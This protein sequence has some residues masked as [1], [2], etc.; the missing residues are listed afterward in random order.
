[1]DDRHTV[2]HPD[3]GPNEGEGRRRRGLKSGSGERKTRGSTQGRGR[4]RGWSGVERGHDL[5]EVAEEKE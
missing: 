3:S 4:G 5:A 1:M 2:P